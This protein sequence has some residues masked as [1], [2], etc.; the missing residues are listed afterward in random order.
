MNTD[1]RKNAKFD[2]E[3]DF[4]KLMNNV[5]F[6]KTMENLIKHRDKQKEE[7]TWRQKQI[8]ILQSFSQKFNFII[9]NIIYQ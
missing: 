4:S 5:V 9:I 1:V 8:I 6:V 7:T 2:F 3:K